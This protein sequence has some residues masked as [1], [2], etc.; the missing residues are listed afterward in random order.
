MQYVVF[1]V[2]KKMTKLPEWVTLGSLWDHSG[3]V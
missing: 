3:I 1:D 2:Q